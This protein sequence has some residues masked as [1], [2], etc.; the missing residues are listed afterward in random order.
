MKHPRFLRLLLAVSALAFAVAPFASAAANSPQNEK[1][2][3]A[4]DPFEGLAEIALTGNVGKIDKAIAVA[5]KAKGTTRSLLGGDGATRF[6][7]L[8]SQLAAARSKSDHIGV[9]LAAAELYKLLVASLDS[10]AL[11]VP[12]EVGLLDYVG[13]RISALLKASP[14]DWIAIA[15]TVTEAHEYWRFVRERVTDLKLRAK[16]DEAQ[17]SL[18]TASQNKDPV[19]ALSAV[20][21]DLDLVDDLERHFAKH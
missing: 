13:F 17:K 18:L 21:S 2:L 9:S 14:N 12:K 4:T 15:A 16:M 1:I 5:Q 11:T 3:K 20:K 19:L 6:D 10:A 8:F 7:A